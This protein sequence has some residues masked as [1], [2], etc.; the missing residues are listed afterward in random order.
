METHTGMLELFLKLGYKNTKGICLGS[1]FR[2][3][4]ACILGEEALFKNRINNIKALIASG[5]DVNQLVQIVKA[6]KGKNLN[7]EDKKILDILAYF[8]SVSIY[9]TPFDFSE[10]FN[11]AFRSNQCNI[12]LHSYF[13]SS[14]Q[15]AARG[16]LVEI[17]S[18]SMVSS[19]EEITR[20]LRD[21]GAVLQ[22][23]SVSSS[24]TL[25]ILLGNT[26]HAIA[27][28]F[29]PNSGWGFM[30]INQ[31]PSR[32]FK[33]EDVSSLTKMIVKG[34]DN[35]WFGSPIALNARV[36]TT[37]NNT[38][39]PSLAQHLEYLKSSHILTKE[40][41]FREQDGVGLAIIAARCG[42]AEVIAKLAKY[43][44]NL[45][46]PNNKG[47]TAACMAANFGYPVVISEL[48][49]YKAD[50][51]KPSSLGNTPACIAAYNGYSNVIVELGKSGANLEKA[52][53][54]GLTPVLIAAENGYAEVI[55]ELAKYKVDFNRPNKNGLTPSF[56]AVRH[57]NANVIVELA[58][59][60]VD[61]NRV[62]K[63]G[64]APVHLAAQ[65]GCINTLAA[66]DKCGADLNKT[67]KDGATPA[68]TA[69]RYRQ[70]EAIVTLA[71][72]KANLNQ[73]DKN[74]LTPAHLAVK[75]ND[76]KMLAALI[77]CGVHL[78]ETVY[79]MA[80]AMEQQEVIQFLNKKAVKTHFNFTG[81]FSSNDIHYLETLRDM[82]QTQEALQ[83][84]KVLLNAATINENRVHG[85]QYFIEFIESHPREF[86][87][88]LTTMKHSIQQIMLENIDTLR[89]AS[90]SSSALYLLSGITSVATVSYRFFTPKPQ[91]IYLESF[92]PTTLD[93]QCK[94]DFKIAAQESY[95]HLQ[96]K[97]NSQKF[98]VNQL[99]RPEHPEL[100]PYLKN[101][102]AISLDELLREHYAKEGQ[103]KSG[104]YDFPNLK[105]SEKGSLFRV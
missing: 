75:N 21:L 35:S 12:S 74:G 105:N 6:K 102:T 86:D 70:R 20:Y 45:D 53:N 97:L 11:K 77:D 22:A 60:G 65:N 78:Q 52:N 93:S 103:I 66:L 24:E 8:D 64:Y 76:T 92:L 72:H 54:E 55:A 69:V 38:A 9:Q 101:I 89:K 100:K 41:A 50:L 67:D 23:S 33:T 40:Q 25:G 82:K 61:L 30:D 4:E 31:Y 79:E 10:V 44:V 96:Q 15:I 16:G 7:Q 46:K 13:A 99:E 17:Y 51:D 90:L 14:D 18:E 104:L 49:K 57:G 37:Q 3:I 87:T 5:Q 62:N 19:S 84:V 85:R 95:D 58:K 32:F 26:K 63:E 73:M 1:A 48:A 81:S 47:W 71:K 91:Q 94:A 42:Q 34:F 59:H 39:L 68:H 28:S 56:A 98:K 36:I 88:F 80:L 83:A 27:L 29:K 2:W 43:K